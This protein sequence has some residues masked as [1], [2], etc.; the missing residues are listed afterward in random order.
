M[1]NHQFQVLSKF[2]AKEVEPSLQDVDTRSE[3]AS[4]FKDCQQL[5]QAIKD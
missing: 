3:F 2:N 1:F 5:R 4:I